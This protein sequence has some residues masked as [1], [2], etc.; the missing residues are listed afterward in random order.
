MKTFE[1]YVTEA[2]MIVEAE[3]EVDAESIVDGVLADTFL[4][5]GFRVVG[6]SE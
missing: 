3:D 5:Y 1:I 6:E 4:D 2:T